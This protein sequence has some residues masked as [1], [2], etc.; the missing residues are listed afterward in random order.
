MSRYPRTTYAVGSDV[1]L[2][3][4]AADTLALATGDTLAVTTADKLT[5]GGVIV[6]QYMRMSFLLHPMATITEWDLWIADR[7]VQV[8]RID[9]VPSTLQGGALTATL[10]KAVA[11]ATP[12]KT[13]TPLHA[14]DAI[15]LNTG[16]YTVQ[17][18]TLTATTADLQFAV[19]NRL[20]VDL[21]G[22]LTTGQACV[23]VTFKLI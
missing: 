17:N 21:S 20:S 1:S 22:A 13:T 3:R 4:T 2:S 5:V 10:V 9:V 18:I 16:A 12:V 6:P 19:G 15:N 11:T 14:A 7:A 23:S 8:T